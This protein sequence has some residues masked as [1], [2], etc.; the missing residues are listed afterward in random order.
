LTTTLRR[1]G[2][3]WELVVSVDRAWLDSRER[4]FPVTIDPSVTMS[5]GQTDCMLTTVSV[6]TVRTMACVGPGAMA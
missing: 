2:S 1:D 5:T 6:T 3:G 4:V